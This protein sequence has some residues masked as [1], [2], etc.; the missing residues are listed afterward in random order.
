MHYLH[1]SLRGVHVSRDVCLWDDDKDVRSWTSDILQLVVQPIRQ[2]CDRRQ[3]FRSVL[4]EFPREGGQFWLVCPSSPQIIEGVQSDQVSAF[5]EHFRLNVI[6]S[7]D[8]IVNWS[9]HWT[10]RL[11]IWEIGDRVHKLTS[12]PSTS[13]LF[14][15]S[16]TV[17]TMLVSGETKH[18]SFK[19]LIAL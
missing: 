4:G 7:D 9:V 8:R 5:F 18:H 1:Y 16:M 11:V 6:T 19:L 17:P 15:V 14:P 13:N 2:H 3:P 12:I 10:I